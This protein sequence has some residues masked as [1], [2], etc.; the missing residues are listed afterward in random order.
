[1][2]RRGAIP[3]LIRAFDLPVRFRAADGATWADWQENAYRFPLI[4]R[5]WDKFGR[6]EGLSVGERYALGG[7]ARSA[8]LWERGPND[9]AVRRLS[10]QGVPGAKGLTAGVDAYYRMAEASRAAAVGGGDIS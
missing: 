4:R 6:G 1:M 7:V 5:A 3:W 9:P 8:L 2:Q 10:G